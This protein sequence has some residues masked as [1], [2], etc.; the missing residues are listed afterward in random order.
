MG[1]GFDVFLRY[2]KFAIELKMNFGLLDLKVDDPDIY[3]SSFE[4][5]HSRTFM[6]SF[7]FEG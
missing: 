4:Y 5:L 3:I 1:M 2:V 7:T 6:L